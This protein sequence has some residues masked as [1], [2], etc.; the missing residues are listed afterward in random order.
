MPS[1]VKDG[2]KKA[3]AEPAGAFYINMAHVNR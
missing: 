3:L 2:M 1:G